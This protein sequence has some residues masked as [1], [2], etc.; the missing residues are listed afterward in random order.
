[1]KDLNRRK[2]KRSLQARE[3]TITALKLEQQLDDE[4]YWTTFQKTVDDYIKSSAAVEGMLRDSY[5]SE[6]L[7]AMTQD[8]NRAAEAELTRVID[9]PIPS[10]KAP[11]NSTPFIAMGDG[12]FG[13]KRRPNYTEKF[14]KTLY[15]KVSIPCQSSSVQKRKEQ[16]QKGN[17]TY[18]TIFLILL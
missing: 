2:T 9:R 6:K 15:T 4:L 14:A 12:K 8:R 18:D 10:V 7:K 13:I 5:G 11:P 16:K 3:Y 17:L 1:M